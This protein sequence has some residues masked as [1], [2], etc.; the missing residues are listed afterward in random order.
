[1]TLIELGLGLVRFEVRH[2]VVMVKV[3]ERG[4]ECIMS[5]TR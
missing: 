4:R 2:L 3:R 5:M 1:L